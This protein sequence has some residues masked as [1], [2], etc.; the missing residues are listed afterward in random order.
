MNKEKILNIYLI[1]EHN[2]VVGFAAKEY[3]YKGSDQEKIE[4][5]KEIQILHSKELCVKENL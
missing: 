3:F 2:K 1:I 4:F 5:L